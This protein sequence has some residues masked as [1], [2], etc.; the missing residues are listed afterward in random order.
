MFF[1]FNVIASLELI[2]SSL[3]L[4]VDLTI[5]APFLPN[6]ITSYSL[7]GQVPY[8]TSPEYNLPFDPKGIPLLVNK[9]NKS[10]NL[11]NVLLLLLTKLSSD[12]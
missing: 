8:N 2:S 7:T 12:I 6:L 3:T 4:D 11:L 9:G 5:L 1:D 10:P